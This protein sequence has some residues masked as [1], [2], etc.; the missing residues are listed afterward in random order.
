[1][2]VN[3]QE[4]NVVMFKNIVLETFKANRIVSL[5][6]YGTRVLVLTMMIPIMILYLFWI[7]MML[8]M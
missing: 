4:Q 1:M 6:F 7:S 5:L 8:W 3:N 2:K